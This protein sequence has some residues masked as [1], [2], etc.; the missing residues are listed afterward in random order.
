MLKT[1]CIVCFV[2]KH[3]EEAEP[4]I[5]A[6]KES[7]REKDELIQLLEERNRLLE[8][9]CPESATEASTPGMISKAKQFI[10]Q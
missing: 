1:I 8:E 6:M 3:E 9:S 10:L 4:A 5:D 2:A 7:I